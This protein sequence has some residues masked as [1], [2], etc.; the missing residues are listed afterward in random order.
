MQ[1]NLEHQG[2]E[3][4]DET[5]ILALVSLFLGNIHLPCR[6]HRHVCQSLCPAGN[7]LLA[8]EYG[9]LT[10]L[11]AAVEHSVVDEST[12]V[13]HLHAVVCAGHLTGSLCDYLIV[14]TVAQ[15]LDAVLLGY[16]G[17]ELLALLLVVAILLHHLVV[18][19]GSH[20]RLGQNGSR[21]HVPQLV[22]ASGTGHKACQEVVQAHCLCAV[23]TEHL[24]VDALQHLLAHLLANLQT[25]KVSSLLLV[26]T[27]VG[28][29]VHTLDKLVDECS[30]NV[31][32]RLQI[33]LESTA[34]GH[35]YGVAQCVDV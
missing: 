26:I 23:L 2:R 12:L 9:G 25:C 28:T 19:D 14:Y 34:L 22:L 27:C 30:V 11:V 13:I 7:H 3:R 5:A 4:L 17:H 33:L 20:H 15:R 1:L 16:L 35:T 32:A 6:T 21:I 24:I 29:V 10:T 8:H 31:H 18:L